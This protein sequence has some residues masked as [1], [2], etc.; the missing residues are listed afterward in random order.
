[1]SVPC[2]NC[3]RS[4]LMQPDLR[5]YQCL[6]CG[7]LTAIADGSLVPNNIVNTVTSPSGHPVVEL[8]TTTP[9]FAGD[10]S[11]SADPEHRLRPGD[12]FPHPSP[13]AT[14]SDTPAVPE[15]ESA[16]EA[17][18]EPPVAPEPEPA[19]VEPVDP[20]PT[21]EP[22]VPDPSTVVIEPAPVEAST[23]EP[24]DLSTLTPEQVSAI[25]AIAHPEA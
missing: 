17:P 22:T 24:I 15:P 5:N 16:P 2:A 20:T 10:E 18:V 11:G 12:P 7:A 9:S 21:P 4:D 3:G 6:A 23:P 1:M 14:V 8:S 13:E 19:P 25:E